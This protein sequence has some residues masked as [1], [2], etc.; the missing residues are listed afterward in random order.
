VGVREDLQELQSQAN[1]TA[2]G[3]LANARDALKRGDKGR[4]KGAVDGITQ[5]YANAYAL[6]AQISAAQPPGATVEAARAAVG[7]IARIKDQILG[8]DRGTTPSTRQPSTPS[9]GA[10]STG[11][12]STTEAAPLSTGK[13]VALGALFVGLA[14]GAVAVARKMMGGK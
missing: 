10:P 9:T 1:Q 11:S 2:P 3:L 13:K 7:K 5:L 6:Q 12:P 14:G 8:L 4:Y